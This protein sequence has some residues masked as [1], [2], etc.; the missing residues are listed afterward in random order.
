MRQ[1]PKLR[2]SHPLAHCD[3]AKAYYYAFVN[4]ANAHPV[5]SN[6]R[7]T[8]HREY[9]NHLSTCEV[10]VEVLEG[11]HAKSKSMFEVREI[12]TAGEVLQP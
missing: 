12:A 3:A 11:L 10:C 4:V 6:V 7:V 1:L 8:A 9:Q 5:G 2:I